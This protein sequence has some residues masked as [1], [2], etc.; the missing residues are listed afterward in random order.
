[1]IFDRLS[2]QQPNSKSNVSRSPVPNSIGSCTRPW[3]PNSVGEAVKIGARII[4]KSGLSTWIGRSWRRGSLTWRELR[5]ATTNF[6]KKTTAACRS[7]ALV[8]ANS[9]KSGLRRGRGGNA[10]PSLLY[11][12]SRVD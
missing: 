4:V 10:S 3:G 5:P 6:K 8:C 11:G 1:M 7:S 9:S 12:A 2:E